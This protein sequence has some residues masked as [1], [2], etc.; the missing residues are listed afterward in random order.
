MFELIVGLGNPG[1]KYASTLHNIGF[2]VV[3][4]C[5]S[6][7][8]PQWKEKFGGLYCQGTMQNHQL[9]FLKP[10]TFMNLSGEAVAPFLRWHK[11]PVE[12]MLVIHDE[13]DLEFGVI[14]LKKDGGAGGHNGLRSI[15]QHSGEHFWRLRV[16]VDKA[17]QGDLSDYLLSPIRQA[18]LDPLIEEGCQALECIFSLG[19]L[20]A[21][22]YINQK[23]S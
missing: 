9:H 5:L 13:V 16:G 1:K 7:Q 8:Q 2:M 18:L 20:K 3:D 21:Q 6:S 19:P 4:A 15:I 22:N 23:K 17:P 12:N 14:R 10:Q 11:F